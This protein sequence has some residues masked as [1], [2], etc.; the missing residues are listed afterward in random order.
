MNKNI[1]SVVSLLKNNGFKRVE[2]NAYDNTY[3][4][5]CLDYMIEGETV[6]VNNQ[7]DIIQELPTNYFAIYGWLVIKKYIR[8]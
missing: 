5:I 4:C 1:K 3:C 7:G 2:K 8:P 6:I